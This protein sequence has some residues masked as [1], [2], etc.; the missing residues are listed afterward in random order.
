MLLQSSALLDLAAWVAIASVKGAVL[1]AAVTT[2]RSLLNLATTSVWR[3]ALWLPVL[4]CLICPLGPGV[5]LVSALPSSLPASLAALPMA[6]SPEA[7]PGDLYGKRG[8]RSPLTLRVDGQIAAPAPKARPSAPSLAALGDGA[9]PGALLASLILI[10]MAGVAALGS[11]YLGKLLKFRRIR[12]A[13]RTVG[14]SASR[15]LEGCNAELRVRRTVR[16]L[17]SDAVESPTVVG[18]LRPTILLPLG[19]DGRLDAARLRHVLLHELAHVKRNDVLVSWIAAFAQFLHWFNPAVWQ[20]GRLM[21]ADMESAC[22]AHVLGRLSRSERG[23]YGDMLLHLAESDAGRVSYG[24]GIADHHGDLK[25]RLVG[26][27]RFRPASATVKL[28]VG[29]ALVILSGAALIQPGLS[30]PLGVSEAVYGLHAAGRT[31]QQRLLFEQ[32]RPQRQVSFT[33]TTFD[34]YAGYYWFADLSLYARVYRDANRYYVQVTG[35]GPVEV[36]AE[37]PTEFFATA[38]PAQVSFA[39]DSDGHVTEMTLHQSGYLQIALRVSKSAYQAA[40]A[41]LRQRITGN[42]PSPGTQASLRA[43]LE[44]WENGKPDY[45]DMGAGL[46]TA[47]REQREQMLRMIRYL[48]ALKGLHFVT[49]NPNGWNVYVAKFSNGSVKCLIA[50]LS[51]EGKVTGLFYLP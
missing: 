26:I 44:G 8:S 2:F 18:W 27:A 36:F 32:T 51:S 15:V 39:T 28:T 33:P 20:A 43:Q 12:L 46:A 19:L 10:W 22:D 23:E 48:G 31:D 17:E 3:H 16:I 37:S 35:K 29:V 14:A 13:G 1:I 45:A 38:V 24:L 49:V 25:T 11:L 9:R 50:P 5:P 7:P 4:A 6:L 40:T 41:K 34:K 21:R 30:S 47:S 42:L